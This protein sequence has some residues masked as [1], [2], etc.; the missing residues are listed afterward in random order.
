MKVSLKWLGDY[1]DIK[2]TIGELAEKLAMA[3]LEVKG[4]Q[5]IGGTWDMW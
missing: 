1:V 5:T 2:L 3:G 4:T